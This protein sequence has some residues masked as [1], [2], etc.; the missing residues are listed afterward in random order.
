MPEGDTIHHLARRVDAALSGQVIRGAKSGVVAVEAS[1]LVGARVLGATA[2]AKHLLVELE[3]GLV[4]HVHLGMNGR[5]RVRRR[6]IDLPPKPS[7]EETRVLLWTDSATLELVA[8]PIC[9]LV[10]AD[11]LEED[12]RLARLGKSPL[13]PDW[14]S[15]DIAP[16]AAALRSLTNRASIADALR[17]QR[18]LSGLGNVLVCEALFAAGADP[19]AS[20]DAFDDAALE[21]VVAVAAAML[22]HT[23]REIRGLPKA[24]GRITRTDDAAMRG[25]ADPYFVYDRARRPCVV[26]GSA[27]GVR[28]EA[29]ES[30]RLTYH[31]PR[32]QP[33]REGFASRTVPLTP[34]KLGLM[35]RYL[36]ELS[37]R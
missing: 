27:V 17:D 9:E 26:C 23:S 25:R 24:P 11:R 13:D 20:V 29:S 15:A 3:G 33:H 28:R 30:P 21:L 19:F 22:R 8:T 10:R 6:A 31:C 35:A 36:R 32:C 7:S 4:L 1:L 37:R 34:P 12:P 5:A 16:A 2:R 14:S 18:A